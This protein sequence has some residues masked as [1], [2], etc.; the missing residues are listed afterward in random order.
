MLCALAFAGSRVEVGKE[1]RA[2][3]EL[4]LRR[5]NRFCRRKSNLFSSL[6]PSP[7]VISFLSYFFRFGFWITTKRRVSQS[8]RLNRTLLSQFLSSCVFCHFDDPLFSLTPLL[9]LILLLSQTSSSKSNFHFYTSV[10]VTLP[11]NILTY[12]VTNLWT[13]FSPRQRASEQLFEK[14]PKTFLV[15]P[16]LGSRGSK[17][18]IWN[19][20]FRSSWTEWNQRTTQ[21]FI[22]VTRWVER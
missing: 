9:L 1:F 16:E 6:F 21:L 15:T 11:Q 13:P 4:E 17:S 10:N 14:L 2:K 8:F 7:S 12:P 20:S 3:L 22:A 5:E 19:W 18:R